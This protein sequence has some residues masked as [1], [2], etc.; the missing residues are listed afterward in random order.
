MAS[1]SEFETVMDHVSAGD[2][3][4]VVGSTMPLD[5]IREAHV[6]LEEGRMFGKLVLEP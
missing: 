3:A 2:L 1:R 5:E 6:M 4:P